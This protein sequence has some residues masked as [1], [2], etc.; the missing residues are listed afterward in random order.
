[1]RVIVDKYYPNGEPQPGAGLVFTLSNGTRLGGMAPF[2]IRWS[3]KVRDGKR[4]ADKGC[5]SNEFTVTVAHIEGVTF[6]VTEVS[7]DQ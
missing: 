6:Y 7:D 4:C 5:P 3:G 1:M 2:G